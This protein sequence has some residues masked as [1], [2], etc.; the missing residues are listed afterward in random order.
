[1]RHNKKNDNIGHDNAF[2]TA[3]I[4]SKHISDYNST[5]TLEELFKDIIP[6]ENDNYGNIKKRIKYQLEKYFPDDT[7][8]EYE[9]LPDLYIYRVPDK[10]GLFRY[11]I[12]SKGDTYEHFHEQK[13]I[14]AKKKLILARI[15]KNI[16]CDV[17]TIYKLDR[18]QQN[19]CQIN[20]DNIEGAAIEFTFSGSEKKYLKSS[21]FII[22][23]K[24]I[25]DNGFFVEGLIYRSDSK[26]LK[27]DAGNETPVI[28][29]N[30]KDNTPLRLNLKRISLSK[31]QNIIPVSLIPDIKT[32]IVLLVRKKYIPELTADFAD[33]N[34]SF[35]NIP[36]KKKSTGG[37][38]NCGEETVSQR[39]TVVLAKIQE[40]SPMK[41]RKWVCDNPYKAIIKEPFE[42]AELSRKDLDNI[43]RNLS[44]SIK[45][46]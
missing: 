45:K 28:N 38:N 36:S 30:K 7:V 33:C 19:I 5:V 25:I 9:F 40:V 14:S 34:I 15:T 37:N 23:M 4:K 8:T 11:G 3:L 1:M 27:P 39:N 21:Y 10:K 35:S 2:V 44:E 26:K 20:G 24:I 43:K 32:N 22:P 46:V 41:V 18:I 29:L 42:I 12:R 31:N 13:D 17:A 16:D 6:K